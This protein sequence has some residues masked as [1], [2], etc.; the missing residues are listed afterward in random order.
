MEQA[1]NY[2]RRQLFDFILQA[3][4]VRS[5]IVR[6]DTREVRLPQE[7]VVSM[8]VFVDRVEELLRLALR[9]AILSPISSGNS[10]VDWKKL[11][12]GD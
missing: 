1:P 9:Q 2:S 5:A 4:D 11:I 6:G 8:D 3:C 10:L 7:G 12:V